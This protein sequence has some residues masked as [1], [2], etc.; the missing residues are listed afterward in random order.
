M[1]HVHL[2]TW[3]LILRKFSEHSHVGVEKSWKV[4]RE[5]SVK[6]CLFSY[7]FCRLRFYT[8]NAIEMLLYN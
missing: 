1:C 5:S 3:P 2:Q 6:R 4:G 8:R 7:A